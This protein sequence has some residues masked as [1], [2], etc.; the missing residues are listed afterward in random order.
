MTNIFDV[1]DFFINVTVNNNQSD[2][3]ITNLKLNKLLYFAQGYSFAMTGKPLFNDKI[4]AWQYGPVVRSVYDKYRVCG[5]EPITSI[6]EDYSESIFST[7]E[8]EIL[9]KVMRDYGKYTGSY[10]IKLTHQDGTPWK[11]VYNQTQNNLIPNDEISDYFKSHA[12]NLFTKKLK[13]SD[14]D[15]I[16][17]HNEDGYLVLPKDDDEEDDWSEYNEP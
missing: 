14:D 11:K 8:L 2:D 12:N 15:C 13:Y 4:E 9:L 17:Y 7:E 10:L 6:D 1:A 5:K 3:F 16:G